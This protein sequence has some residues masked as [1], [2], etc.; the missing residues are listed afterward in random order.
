VIAPRADLA[1]MAGYH[2]PRVEVAVRLNVNESPLPPPAEWLEALRTELGQVDF[3]RYPDRRAW[4]L[5]TALG[6]FHGVGPEQIFAANGSNEVLQSLLLAFGGPGRAAA[7]FEPTYALHSHIARIT[8][9]AVATGERD[10]DFAIDL[11]EVSRVVS[12]A[13]PALT[14]MCSPNNPTG[15]ADPAEVTEAVLDLAPGLVVVDEAYGQFSRWSALSLVAHGAGGGNG[16]P[17]SDRLVVVRT[18]SKTWSMAGVR[19]GY[20]IG[21]AAVVGA[22]EQVALPYH[23]DSVKQVAGRL[24]LDY[25]AEM[26][27]RVGLL[28]EERGRLSCALGQ[29]EVDAWPSEANFIMFRPRRREGS[30]V[31]SELVERSVLVRDCSSWPRLAG[32][33]RVTVGTPGE[34]TAFLAA[35]AEVLEL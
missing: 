22:L 16:R 12:E 11:S 19:L 6:R 14:F 20:L 32:C 35:L 4:E 30:E 1:L 18:F 28:V 10:Q 2:S 34:N 27:A 17:S 7:V 26:Q 21:P 29:M 24:A 23:L 15:R 33:L 9:T 8:G 3:H 25:Q 31:W 13:Q 5:R